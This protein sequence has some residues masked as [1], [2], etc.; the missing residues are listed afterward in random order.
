M[1]IKS[2]PFLYFKG[3]CSLDF[4]LIIKSKGSYN[5]PAR[6]ITY[7]SVPGRNGDLITDNGRYLNVNIPYEFTLI[8]NDVRTF[9]ELINSVKTWLLSETGYFMLW[10]SYD[11]RYFRYA[12]YNGGLDTVSDL[13]DIGEFSISFNCKPFR[14]SF[15]GQKTITISASETIVNPEAFKAKPYIRIYGSGNISLHINSE[16]YTFQNVSD[17]IEIDS[18]IM[19]VYK[20][21][22]LQN[23]KMSGYDFPKLIPGTNNISFTGSVTKAEIIP[24]WCTL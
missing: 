7:T 16:T 18:E 8:K 20:G 14:Y 2:L 13:R 9:E 22:E 1:I 12:S 10:D 23:H 3:K 4:N 5:A 24:R 21:L 15:D 6:D 19:N 17:Y 11:P